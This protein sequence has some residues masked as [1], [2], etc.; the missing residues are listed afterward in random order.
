MANV[1]G[2]NVRVEIGLTMASA[3]EVTAIS[4]ANPAV[5]TAPA[6]NLVAGRVGYFTGVEGMA[7]LEG[8]AARVA[9]PDA[10]T[11]QLPDIDSTNYPDYTDGSFVPVLTWATVAK[12]TSYVIGGG[13]AESLNSTVL[14]DDQAQTENGLLAAQT[15]SFNLLAEDVPAA[16][17]RAIEQAALND[18]ALVFRIT[19]KTGAQRIFRGTPSMP[20]EDVQQGQLGTGTVSVQVKGRVLKLGAVA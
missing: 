6:H 4:K 17:M 10:N 18:Q 7:Q 9:A 12:A 19:L 15:V 11:F 20:G 3:I 2:R 14:L 16:A 5:A 1:K 8:Q 13:E